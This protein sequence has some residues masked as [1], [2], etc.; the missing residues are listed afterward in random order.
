MGLL[1]E[2]KLSLSNGYGYEEVSEL[3][4][5]LLFTDPLVFRYGFFCK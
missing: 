1:K 4:S 2:E 5:S 3:I